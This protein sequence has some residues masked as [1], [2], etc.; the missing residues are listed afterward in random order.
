VNWS[1]APA[2]ILADAAVTAIDVMGLAV[3]VRVVVPLTPLTDAVIVEVPTATPVAIPEAL[4]VATVV[5][6]DVQF[7]VELTSPVDPSL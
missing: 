1:V 3:T 4:M 5:V 7:A 6:A 2:T